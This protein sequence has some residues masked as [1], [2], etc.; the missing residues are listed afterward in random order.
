MRGKVV[1]WCLL[2]IAICLIAVCIIA[3]VEGQL[4]MG[5]TVG[6]LTL[7]I[8]V[9]IEVKDKFARQQKEIDS[10]RKAL[11]KRSIRSNEEE[12]VR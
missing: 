6:V 3:I 4:V 2:V 5:V 8:I 9:V 11:K 10:L 12:V 1:D 7:L